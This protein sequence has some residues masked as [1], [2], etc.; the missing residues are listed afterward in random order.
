MSVIRGVLFS[1]NVA[2]NTAN[3]HQADISLIT[4][5]PGWS[6]VVSVSAVHVDGGAAVIAFGDEVQTIPVDENSSYSGVVDV[7]AI[8]VLH[9]SSGS[10]DAVIRVLV[11]IL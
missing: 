7:S 6:G 11:E 8:D 9:L 1:Q 2:L 5:R 10:T 4:T 3:E